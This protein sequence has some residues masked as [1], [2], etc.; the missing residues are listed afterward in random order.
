MCF[1]PSAVNRQNFLRLNKLLPRSRRLPSLPLPLPLAPLPMGRGMSV[2]FRC[3]L[4]HF[5][6][7]YVKRDADPRSVA[8]RQKSAAADMCS[9]RNIGELAR[10]RADRH[11]GDFAGNAALGAGLDLQ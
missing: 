10:E 2:S 9:R 3:V 4:R 11:A 7:V 1:T 6:C 8:P 5:E